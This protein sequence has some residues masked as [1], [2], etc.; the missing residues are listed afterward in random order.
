M[1]SYLHY[2]E[3]TGFLMWYNTP[4]LKD[5]ACQRRWIYF[6]KL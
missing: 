3:E 2:E 6:V 5:C 4:K 1:T